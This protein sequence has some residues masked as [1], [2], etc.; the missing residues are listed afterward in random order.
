MLPVY[1]K[2]YAMDGFIMGFPIYTVQRENGIMANFYGPLGLSFKTPELS[3]KMAGLKKKALLYA[4][5]CGP[6]YYG[7]RQYR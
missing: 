4:L 7:I 5:G 6:K 2:L 1:E 3:R